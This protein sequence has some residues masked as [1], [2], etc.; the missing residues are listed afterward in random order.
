V[1]KA[2]DRREA[3]Y[4]LP[5]AKQVVRDFVQGAA[6]GNLER[7]VATLEAI[8]YGAVDGGGWARAMRAAARLT[9]VPRATRE[10]FLQLYLDYGDSIRQECDDLDLMAGLRAL[11]P[12]YKGAAVRLYRG[13]SFYNRSRRTYG[14]SWT[15]S[16]EVARAYAE[17]GFYRTFKG[18]SVLLET[19]A[20]PS[21]II[22][23]PALLDDRYKESEYIVDRRL[24]FVRLI[25]RFNQAPLVA[26]RR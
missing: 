4:C 11:L 13:E 25:E 6:S 19:L 15:A 16:R 1:A 14:L 22:C 3:A 10:F 9:S 5:E 18:G 26:L 12:K 21:A 20:P 17:T 2:R 23:A 7:M 8:H 24:T